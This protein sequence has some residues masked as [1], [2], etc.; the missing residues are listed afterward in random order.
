M[1]DVLRPFHVAV[2]GS[3]SDVLRPFRLIAPRLLHVVSQALSL[4]TALRIVR[5]IPLALPSGR[6]APGEPA[7]DRVVASVGSATTATCETVQDARTERG[8]ARLKVRTVASHPCVRARRG[9]LLARA[10][11]GTRSSRPSRRRVIPD[12][13]NWTP[14]PVSNLDALIPGRPAVAAPHP[15]PDDHT[16]V[17]RG[18]ELGVETVDTVAPYSAPAFP[19]CPSPSPCPTRT[20]STMAWLG[21]GRARRGGPVSRTGI[22]GAG[23]HEAARR[24]RDRGRGRSSRPRRVAR[25]HIDHFIF[26][27]PVSFQTAQ[28]T[29]Q[30]V[31]PFSAP[32]SGLRRAA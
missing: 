10:P 31:G 9:S 13:P 21:R 3:K 24:L 30:L 23:V 6:V 22:A 11:G 4:R 20:R 32:I 25:Y 15:A 1:D 28:P 8:R 16:A 26:E 17:A 14:Q 7:P 19:P 2:W 18:F 29:Q 27:T 12:C 5:S